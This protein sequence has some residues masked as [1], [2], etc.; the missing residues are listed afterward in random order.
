MMNIEA[1]LSAR[2]RFWTKPAL[3]VAAVTCA[4]V[5]YVSPGAAAVLGDY[6]AKIIGRYGFKFEVQ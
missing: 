1:T 5:E 3:M 4:L 2:Q 6:A